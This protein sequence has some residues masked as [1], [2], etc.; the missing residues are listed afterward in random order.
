[1]RK[2][3]HSVWKT[4]SRFYLRLDRKPKSWEHRIILFVGFLIQNKRKSTTIKSYISVIRTIL[5]EDKIKLNEDTFQ[6]NALTRACRLTVDRVKNRLPIGKNILVVILKY[7]RIHYQ[8]Q[9][10]LSILFRTIFTK[11]QIHSQNI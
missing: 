1:M 6:L 8:D 11:D 4:F 9:P 7:T 10:Y 2:I 3:Y 5:R